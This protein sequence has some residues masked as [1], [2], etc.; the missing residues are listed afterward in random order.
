MKTRADKKQVG[1][2]GQ[3]GSVAATKRSRVAKARRKKS[4]ALMRKIPDE[5]PPQEVIVNQ[6][7]KGKDQPRDSAGK[8]AKA[9]VP[10]DK[11]RKRKASQAADGKVEP[12]KLAE[13]KQMRY[14]S[15]EEIK[16]TKAGRR[17]SKESRAQQ[18]T[19][20]DM[21]PSPLTEGKRARETA[22]G[23]PDKAAAAR[24]GLGKTKHLRLAALVATALLCLA[25]LLWVYTGTGVLNVKKVVVRGNNV[26]DSAYLRSLSGIT[27]DTHLLKMDV[28]A[29]EEALSSEPYVASASVSRRFPNTVVLDIEEREPRGVIYQNGK[30]HLVD[31]WGVVLGSSG[32]KPPGLAEIKGVDVPLLYPGQQISGGN[33]A[34]VAG[35]LDNMPPSL[36]EITKTI[37]YRNDNKIYLESKGT[38][39]IYG[40][41]SDLSRKNNIAL[42][43][44]TGLVSHYQGVEYI[45]VSF[46]DHPVIKPF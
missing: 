12:P 8:A 28:K 11:K 21:E 44:L 25:A 3:E 14:A 2:R 10:P 13:G 23:D 24:R 16:K 35:L 46:P 45:D 4:H 38:T 15:G 42:L 18:T 26:L 40:E 33:F 30:F 27:V 19:A 7:H 43:A 41:N 39:V 5:I 22:K 31:Q 6:K 32:E 37:G 9:V 36:R 17:K 34:A 1:K 20:R 29:V